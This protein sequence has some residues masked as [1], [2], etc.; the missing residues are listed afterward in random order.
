[1]PL[2]RWA[3]LLSLA[4]FMVH[5]ATKPK[6]KLP[7]H[8]ARWLNQEV[9]YII[10]PQ[11]KKEF[12]ALTNDDARDKFMEDF[13][14]TRNPIRGASPNQ[15]RE[16]HYARLAFVNANF[17][18]KSNT[19]GWMTDMGRT[20]IVFGKHDSR[21]LYTGHGQIYPF[22]LWFYSNKTNNPDFPSFFYTLFFMPEDIGEYKL[23]RPYLDGPLKLVRG[24]TFNTNASVYRFLFPLSGELARAAFSLI[25]GEPLDTQDYSVSMGSDMLVTRIQNYAN[26]P[27]YVKRINQL[28]ALRSKVTSNF[29]VQD[30]RPLDVSLLSL[31]DPLGQY[32]LDYSVLVNTGD[33]GERDAP[34]KNL[35]G[36]SGYK[37]KH[38]GGD[39][40]V[41]DH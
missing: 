40:I 4:A 6:E 3:L 12:L 15:F 5:A 21:A 36:E 8:Y 38:E 30:G 35:T 33:L 34:P 13:W 37:L 14:E 25:P 23:Y 26:D 20:W 28:R 41:A 32:W 7:E 1:M 18:R 22:E 10:T 9:V 17:G 19:P 2:A 39:V 11:E 24:S 16:E 27:F 29:F 31:A